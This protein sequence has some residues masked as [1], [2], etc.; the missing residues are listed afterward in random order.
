MGTKILY[1]LLA[2]TIFMSC[3]T[4]KSNDKPIHAGK[5]TVNLKIAVLPTTDCLPFYVAEDM[6]IYKKLGLN[7]EFINYKS[8]LKCNDA[9]EKGLIDGTFTTL[10]AAMYLKSTKGFDLKL[11]MRTEGDVDVIA[12]RTKRIK[13]LSNMRERLVAITRHSTSDY[14][15]DEICS[16]TKMPTFEILRPQINDIIIRRQM[17]ASNQVD[18]VIIPRP[19]SEYLL[20]TG[21][22]K[23]FSTQNSGIKF[24]C[25][26][27]ADTVIKKKSKQIELLIKG[28]EQAAKEINRN[29]KCAD[30]TL[31]RQYVIPAAMLDSLSIPQYP[32]AQSIKKSDY[33]K[34]LQ[35]CIS[36]K[37]VKSPIP[38]KDLITSKYITK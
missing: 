4:K 23:V 17:L 7:V 18:A 8:I 29:R 16:I 34:S 24:G 2:I 25:L 35:W 19:H 22:V 15:A 9:L 26:A 11:V 37:Y 6:N 20:Q 30:T 3:S 27:I 36:R 28:Y 33:D 32:K 21:N 12:S 14:L 5:D 38:E 13:K 10:P 31:I 1:A